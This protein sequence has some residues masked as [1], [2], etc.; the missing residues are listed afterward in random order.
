M[1]SDT[2]WR[3]FGVQGPGRVHYQPFDRSFQPER[4]YGLILMLDVLEH[5]EDAR[6]ALSHAVSLLAPGGKLVVT[7]PA[8]R[9]LWTSH[10]DLNHHVT[11]YTRKDFRDLA[12]KA[13]FRLDELRYFFHWLFF[14]KAAV[15]AKEALLKPSKPETPSI[16]APW[17]N[18]LLAR[19]SV[20]E[21]NLLGPLSLPFGG[22]LLAVGGRGGGLEPVR[23]VEGLR[24][25][26]ED[27]V[28]Q[29]AVHVGG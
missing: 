10:D 7:V 11:R 23:G 22:S 15:R 6:G 25:I 8:F 20:I 14:A 9:K 19:G 24:L 27:A 18:R 12:G 26:D 5:L 1:E 16:P 28:E 29:R 2:S 17:L 13:G 21:S 4:R 3:E